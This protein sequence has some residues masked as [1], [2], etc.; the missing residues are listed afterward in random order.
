MADVRFV[1]DRIV[2]VRAME[3]EHVCGCTGRIHRV[4]L[5]TSDGNVTYRPRRVVEKRE[6][7]EGHTEKWTEREPISLADLPPTLWELNK[8][9][10][11]GVCKVKLSYFVWEAAIGDARTPVWFMREKQIHEIEFLPLE[12]KMSGGEKGPVSG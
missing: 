9:L 4:L 7:K 5:K 6:E 3:I 11:G 12:E 2:C 10:E 8:R 1:K